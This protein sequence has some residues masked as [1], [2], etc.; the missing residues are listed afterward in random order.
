MNSAT[1]KVSYNIQLQLGEPACHFNTLST[2]WGRG[3]LEGAPPTCYGFE[4][5]CYDIQLFAGGQLI[6]FKMC[7]TCRYLYYVIINCVALLL[8]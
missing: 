4:V 8:Q 3:C 6:S 2:E 7:P 1:V 5:F